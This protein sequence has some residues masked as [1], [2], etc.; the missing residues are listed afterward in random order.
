MQKT[1]ILEKTIYTLGDLTLPDA[2]QLAVAGRSNVGK[3][4]LINRLAGRKKLAKISSTPGKTQ[5]VNLYRVE[6]GSYFLV[7]L[8]GYGY[9]RRS[10]A[11]RDKWAQLIERY[12]TTTAQLRAVAVLL[13][14]RLPPQ[15]SDLDMVSYLGALNRQVLGVLTKADKCSKRD[16]Q[17]RKAQWTG[18]LGG[19]PPVLFSSVTGMGQEELWSR[20]DALLGQDEQSAEE[21]AP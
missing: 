15:A 8:P 7:D 6:P 3:S 20:V 18:L 1:L 16:Q 14:C 12:L 13:D 9:A 5:S 17:A 4:S 19:R 10:K 21:E 11:E 2:P